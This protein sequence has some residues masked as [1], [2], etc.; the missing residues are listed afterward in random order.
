MQLP[1]FSPSLN[2]M[3]RP[4]S[5]RLWSS[6]VRWCGGRMEPAVGDGVAPRRSRERRPL[7]R[8]TVGRARKGLTARIMSTAPIRLSWRAGCCDE[9]F[10]ASAA[11]G[12]GTGNP[13]W[14]I[15]CRLCSC[16]TSSLPGGRK[17][18]ATKRAGWTFAPSVQPCFSRQCEWSRNYILQQDG[19]NRVGG[20]RVLRRRLV[21]KGVV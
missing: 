15:Y 4:F 21:L 3:N 5:G 7:D 14:L 20:R 11:P 13:T 12:G 6:T 16:Y 2:V 8:E 1:K 9:S 10:P 19:K 17:D 18:V